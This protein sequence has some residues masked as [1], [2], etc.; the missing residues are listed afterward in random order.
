[1]MDMDLDGM[2]QACQ[3]FRDNIYTDK[4]LAVVREWTCNA[5]DEHLKHAVARPVEIGM[6]EDR[7]FVRDFAKGLSDDGIRNVFGKYFRSTK[8]NSDQPIGGFGVGAKAGHC[9]NDVFYV[10]SFFEGVKTVYSCILGGDDTG[11]SIGQVVELSQEP[12][13]ETGLLVEIEVDGGDVEDFLRHAKDS[14]AFA[15]LADIIVKRG[16]IHVQAPTKRL[17]KERD[18]IK[19][20]S[21]Q[22]SNLGVVFTMGGVRYDLP[23]S[24]RMFDF[25]SGVDPKESI[26]VDAPV[27]FFDVPISRESFRDT[28]KFKAN[29]EKCGEFLKSIVDEEAAPFLGKPLSFYAVGQGAQGSF[30]KFRN[31]KFIPA[32]VA[33][34]LSNIY[35]RGGD[36]ANHLMFGKKYAVCLTSKH[37]SHRANQESSIEAES[38]SKGVRVFC[39]PNDLIEN[40]QDQIAKHGM[41]SDLVFGKWQKFFPQ[42]KNKNVCNGSFSVYFVGRGKRKSMTA[43]ELHNEIWSTQ[44]TS[45]QEARD[46][47][48]DKLANVDNLN[49]LACLC[50]SEIGVA[51]YRFSAKALRKAML[52]LGYV[53]KQD[54]TYIDKS[55]E[56]L[57][58]KDL[59][60]EARH[61]AYKLREELRG[62]VSNRTFSKIDKIHWNETG[63]KNKVMI[64]K[65]AQQMREIVKNIVATQ[66]GCEMARIFLRHVKTSSYFSP[67]R[68]EIRLA[69]KKLA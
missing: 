49:D 32:G 3:I 19:I 22:L 40:L 55:A 64:V 59:E 9:Y 15:T 41:Q 30:F 50:C 65:R 66:S 12:T 63:V 33:L 24:W 11:A 26:Q 51:S 31:K 67:K 43:L 2:K 57:K 60:A 62:F 45:H 27:G 14:A 52:D 68:S 5:V 1:M 37:W 28:H 48:T 44:H 8:S 54:Q 6:K 34:A 36:S 18:G 58:K 10:T 69:I 29:M 16:D 56:L 35:V 38:Q 39:F 13:N 20:Y 25:M 21:I 61:A 46:F 42:P 53:T 17:I 7:F 47:V 4:I 23:S